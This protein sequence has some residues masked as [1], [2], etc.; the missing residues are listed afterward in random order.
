MQKLKITAKE[1]TQGDLLLSF[2]NQSGQPV[3]RVTY[4]DKDGN[5]RLTHEGGATLLHPDREVEVYRA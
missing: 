2:I 3:K 1:I 4:P 5:V